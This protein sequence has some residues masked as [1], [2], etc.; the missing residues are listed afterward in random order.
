[1]GFNQQNG[2]YDGNI[3]YIPSNDNLL[4]YVGQH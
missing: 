2:D 3:N 4:S 1:M